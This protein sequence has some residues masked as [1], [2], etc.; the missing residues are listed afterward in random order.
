LKDVIDGTSKTLL[1]GEVGR[2]TSE[3][4][5]AFNG[6][7]FPGVHIGWGRTSSSDHQG[8]CERPANGPNDPEPG[9]GGFGSVHTGVVLFVMCDGSVQPI[10]KDTELKVLDAM[11]TRAGGETYTLEGGAPQPD[12]YSG[13]P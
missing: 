10:S 7:H 8:F 3:R 4:G 11:A 13:L 5:H 6:D 12:C 2:G 9:D 1:A